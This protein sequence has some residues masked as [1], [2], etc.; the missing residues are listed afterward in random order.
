ME[1]R[2]AARLAFPA[3]FEAKGFA[4]QEKSTH[5]GAFLFE[6]DSA[7]YKALTAAQD[8]VAKEKWGDKATAVMKG[9][10]LENRHLVKD[11]DSKAEYGGYEGM[12]FVNASNPVRPTVIDRDRSPLTMADGKPYGGCYVNAIV[13]VWP[14]DNKFGKR[15]NA[16][17]LGVQ[18]VKDGDAF[19]AGSTI[20]S[21][22]QFDEVDEG[23]DAED[24][25]E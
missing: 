6:K 8:K 22:D 15:I 25:L 12:F 2:F 23:A 13:D 11:G 18:F 4:G 7:A 14:Q 5:S 3:L 10:K 19:S 20:A 1:V 24:S 17:L 21:A 9:I 16:K